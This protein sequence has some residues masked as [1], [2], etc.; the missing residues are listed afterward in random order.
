M[1]TSPIRVLAVE[2]SRWKR[3]VRG[4]G[5]YVTIVLHE[6]ARA[7]PELRFVLFAKNEADRRVIAARAESDTALR[8]RAEVRLLRELPRTEADVFWYPWNAIIVKPRAGAIVVTLHDVAP[9]AVPDPRWTGVFKNLRAKWRYQEVARLATRVIAI[10]DFTAREVERYLGIGRDRMDVVL[11]G[12]DGGTLPDPSRDADAL[13]RLGVTGRYVLAVGAGDRRKNFPLLREVMREV[14]AT[15]P[16]V[17]L[18]SA[19]PPRKGKSAPPQRWELPVGFVS[20]EDLWTLYRN[21]AVFVMTSRYEGFGLPIIEAMRAGAPVVCT[22]AA[23]LP[24]VGG[25]AAQYVPVD[26]RA[27]MVTAISAV[28][29]DPGRAAAMRAASLA[30]AAGFFTWAQCGAATLAALDAAAAT[31]AAASPRPR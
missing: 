31:A 26:D 25:D 22:G 9:M 17:R 8:G 4:I 29:D 10:S 20:D 18:V 19:G 24:E 23:S 3:D 5:R 15:R 2:T 13:A 28:L 30:Q 14:A 7:R 12:G 1:S 16:D 11:D 6:M 21:A 27:A